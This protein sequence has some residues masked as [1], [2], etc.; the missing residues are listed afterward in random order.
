MYLMSVAATGF[1]QRKKTAA[2][3]KRQKQEGNSWLFQFQKF[4]LIMMLKDV[5]VEMLTSLESNIMENG[6]EG[7][8]FGC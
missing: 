7:N 5:K 2:R 6:R 3:G 4:A 1:C 8:C